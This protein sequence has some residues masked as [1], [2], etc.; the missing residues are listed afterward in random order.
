MKFSTN[1]KRSK[2]LRG[3]NL[4]EGVGGHQPKGGAGGGGGP[5]GEAQ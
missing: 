3:E 1:K 4:W 2:L 5:G